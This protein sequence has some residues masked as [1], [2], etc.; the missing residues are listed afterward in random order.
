MNNFLRPPIKNSGKVH[1]NARRT[2]I[3]LAIRFDDPQ[4]KSVILEPLNQATRS[5]HPDEIKRQYGQLSPS[6]S[7]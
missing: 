4:E 3:V 6:A 7:R 5:L 2:L 1:R